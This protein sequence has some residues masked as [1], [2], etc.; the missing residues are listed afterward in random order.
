MLEQPAYMQDPL[1]ANSAA[2]AQSSM[3]TPPTCDA[4]SNQYVRVVHTNGVHHIAL[5]F[6][7]CQGHEQ[8][9]TD[10]IYAGWMPTSFV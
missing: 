7:T 4:L 5:V 1:G 9:T 3:P 2:P 10:L 6:F 8:I